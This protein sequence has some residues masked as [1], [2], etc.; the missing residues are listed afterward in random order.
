MKTRIIGKKHL[1]V[2]WSIAMIKWKYEWAVLK[3]TY[4]LKLKAKEWWYNKHTSI[5]TA[6]S[7]KRKDWRGVVEISMNS[8]P[9]MNETGMDASS[10][11]GP[12]WY[13]GII[14]LN[15]CTYGWKDMNRKWDVAKEHTVVPSHQIKGFGVWKKSKV[16][17]T[18]HKSQQHSCGV[19]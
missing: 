1:K 7:E 16:I 8:G 17:R 9:W 6:R 10:Y 19:A 3:W 13:Y 18:G 15:I 2:G 4:S 14:E 12:P 5:L 11:R